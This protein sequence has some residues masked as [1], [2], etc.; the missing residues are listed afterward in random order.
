LSPKSFW[1]KNVEPT[2]SMLE[3]AASSTALRLARH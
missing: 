1:P 2:L 3:P